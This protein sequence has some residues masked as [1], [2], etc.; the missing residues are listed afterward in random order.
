MIIRLRSVKRG[1]GKEERKKYNDIRERKEN[2][3]GKNNNKEKE[4][5]KDP[6]GLKP[7]ESLKEKEKNNV[8][9]N[10]KKEVRFVCVCVYIGSSL[11]T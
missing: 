6:L 2:N 3:K 11:H 10:A 8:E 4:S 7:P 5:E 9:S 1:C